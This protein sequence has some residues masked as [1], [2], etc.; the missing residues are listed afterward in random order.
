MIGL[1][2]SPLFEVRAFSPHYLVSDGEFTDSTSMNETQIQLFLKQRGSK[3]A[4]YL[5]KDANGGVRSAAH[6]IV[7]SA[8][9]NRI[10]PRVLLVLVQKE[11]SLVEGATP[12]N[13]ELNWA[14]G[15]GVCDNCSKKDPAIQKFKG[16]SQQVD[17]AAKRLRYYIDHP[18]E[19]S[20]RPNRQTRIDN[21]WITPIN[22]ATAALYLYTPHIHGNLNFWNI[23]S[24][25]FAR[26]YPDGTLLRNAASNEVWF[27]EDGT[28]RLIKTQAALTTRF[29]PSRIVTVSPAE[30]E[31]YPMG[32]PILLPAFSLVRSPRGTVFL[33]TQTGRRGITSKYVLSSL[34]YNPDEILPIGWNDLKAY[35]EEDS[36]SEKS[37]YPEGTLLANTTTNELYIVQ[38]GIRHPVIDVAIAKSRF[39]SKHP[40]PTPADILMN[41]PLG[42]AIGFTDGTL[43]KAQDTP[44]V[45]VIEHGKR[46]PVADETVFLSLNYHWDQVVSVAPTIL[47]IHPLGPPIDIAHEDVLV[48]STTPRTTP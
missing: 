39:G 46:R 22:L 25:W 42:D 1:T 3:L 2:L 30:L 34:G 27:I 21:Q 5:P 11:Q 13:H 15:Y 40:T 37:L 24:R 7:S 14:M 44:T 38:D 8:Q 6:I 36:I 18:Q 17:Y 16:F 47:N 32:Y 9:R 4:T 43:I 10:N 31:K 48:A 26:N 28:R 45:Y 41:Y 35:P 33:I 19:F 23:W 12:S 29:D 20:I